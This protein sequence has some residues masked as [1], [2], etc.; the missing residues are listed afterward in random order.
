M[1]LPTP[2]ALNPEPKGY[3]PGDDLTGMDKSPHVGWV[4]TE[5]LI[6]HREY[7]RAGA[8]DANPDSRERIDQIRREFRDHGQREPVVLMRPSTRIAR[9]IRSVAGEL[10]GMMGLSD[11]H[12]AAASSQGAP[13]SSVFKRLTRRRAS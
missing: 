5:A 4:K 12:P 8:D 11:E 9:E 10:I 13:R 1:H 7:D 2:S 6:K 3:R